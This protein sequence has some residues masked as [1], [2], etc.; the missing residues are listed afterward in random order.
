MRDNAAITCTVAV[1]DNGSCEEF[2]EWVEYEYK[3]AI[4]IRSD[5]VG[6]SAARA[7][8]FGMFDPA[9]I[10]NYSDDD[11]YHYPNWLEPQIRLLNYFPDVASVTGYPVRT[12]FRWGVERTIK[13]LP[14]EFGRFIPED[15]EE[16]FATSIG[17]DVFEHKHMTEHDR[18]IIVTHKDMKAFG[19]SHH[20]QFIGRAGL[21]ATA[22]RKVMMFGA[23]PDEKP[24]DIELDRVGNRLATLQRYTRHMGNVLDDDLRRDILEAERVVK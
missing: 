16:D 12:A 8:L 5:N 21:L 22:A 17:R 2:R 23:M 20:C 10:V 15:W 14:H 19:T 24:F 13:R 9:T 4:F 11:M 6:K 1:W 3:P 18:D 7:A